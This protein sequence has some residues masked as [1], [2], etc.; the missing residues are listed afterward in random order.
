MLNMQ[1]EVRKKVW[2]AK[3]W[4][5]KLQKKIKRAGRDPAGHEVPALR[6]APNIVTV[7]TPK[8]AKMTQRTRKDPSLVQVDFQNTI[9]TPETQWEPDSKKS[10]ENQKN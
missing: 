4:S 6:L 2:S 1:Q 3:A 10:K 8:T 7:Q 5:K 9:D